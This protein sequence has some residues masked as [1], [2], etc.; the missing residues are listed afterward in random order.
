MVFL[1]S[2]SFYK[3]FNH[4]PAFYF[5]LPP[6]WR[7]CAAPVVDE[8][9]SWIDLEPRD[10]SPSCSGKEQPPL[11]G[12]E[13]VLLLRQ[14]CGS[15]ARNCSEGKHPRKQSESSPSRSSSPTSKAVRGGSVASAGSVS[16]VS[17]I[18]DPPAVRKMMLKPAV[19]MDIPAEVLVV[20]TS[21]VI[22]CI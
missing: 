9:Y 10:S 21:D 2:T 18:G 13:H 8:V 3:Y 16:S 7:S 5:L 20:A 19:F 15:K 14:P 22:T 17:E 1:F 12:W 4:V 11:R 6:E